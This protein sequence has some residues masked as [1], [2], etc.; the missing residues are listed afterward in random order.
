M[1]GCI[2]HT[3]GQLKNLDG[4]IRHSDH[5]ANKT[6][7]IFVNSSGRVQIIHSKKETAVFK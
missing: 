2:R 4:C 6:D 1:K 5:R 3:P 7:N